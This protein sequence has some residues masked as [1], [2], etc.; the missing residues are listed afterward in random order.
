[1]KGADPKALQRPTMRQSPV[2]GFQRRMQRENNQAVRNILRAGET[3]RQHIDEGKDHDNR[4]QDHKQPQRPATNKAAAFH[5]VNHQYKPSSPN[6]L[7]AL[8]ATVIST[9]PMTAFN[10]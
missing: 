9:T 2:V 8:F 6:F 7:A 5:P 10:N 3:H 4:E 1:E